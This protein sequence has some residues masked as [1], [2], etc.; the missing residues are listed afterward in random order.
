MVYNGTQYN[1]PI[2]YWITDY[3]PQYPPVV[4]VQPTPNMAIKPRHPHVGS[5]GTV[6]HP[7]IT[8]WRPPASRLTDLT[9][10]LSTVFGKDPPVF[11][12]PSGAAGPQPAH[13]PSA[14]TSASHP[15]PSAYPP[16]QP[17]QQYDFQ[18]AGKGVRPRVSSP[19]YFVLTSDIFC[20]ALLPASDNGHHSCSTTVSFCLVLEWLSYWTARTIWWTASLLSAYRRAAP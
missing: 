19:L 3:F 1:V 8:N 18:Q 20:D 6:Y 13:P 4:L 16:Q 17:H 7:Y 5:D 2:V 9:K 14:A 10:Q 12:R 15:R 11:A